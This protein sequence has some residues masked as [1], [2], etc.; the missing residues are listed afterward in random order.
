MSDHDQPVAASL[1][2]RQFTAATPNQRE[3]GTLPSS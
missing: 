2:D 1:L 3:A